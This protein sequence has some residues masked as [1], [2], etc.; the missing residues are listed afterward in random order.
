MLI[1]CDCLELHYLTS[2]GVPARFRIF[3][4]TCTP[5]ASSKA[6]SATE[7]STRMHN[8]V[9]SRAD[10]SC[11]GEGFFFVFPKSEDEDSRL[12][13]KGAEVI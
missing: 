8:R 7:E 12:R 9:S 1:W 6:R 5:F 11:G 3:T 4:A 2:L 13:F 10:A